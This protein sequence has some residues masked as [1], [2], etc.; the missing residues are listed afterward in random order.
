MA[1]QT[2]FDTQSAPFPEAG[3]RGSPDGRP[4]K[5]VVDGFDIGIANYLQ[6]NPR[7][8]WWSRGQMEAEYTYYTIET[9]YQTDMGLQVSPSTAA[10]PTASSPSENQIV[11][12]RQQITFKIVSW[13]AQRLHVK[14]LLPHWQ[15]SNPNEKL[16]SRT[17]SACNPLQG[18][19]SKI[20][21]VRGQYTYGFKKEPFMTVDRKEYFYLPSGKTPAEN[22]DIHPALHVY[23]QD[24]LDFVP[25][26]ASF[27]PVDAPLAGSKGPVGY[28]GRT[29]QLDRVIVNQPREGPPGNA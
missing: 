22:S 21:E 23:T 17:I 6:A 11:R 12:V 18:L 19:D 27:I 5:P 29:W 28:N 24:D 3:F 14:P 4:V 26:D 9:T 25:L 16:L 7:I 20:W 10:R 2:S 13:I 15:T 8:D 1:I